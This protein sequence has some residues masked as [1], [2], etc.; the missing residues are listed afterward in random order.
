MS[1]L[2]YKIQVSPR[3]RHVRL[4]VTPAD[5]LCV[6]IPRGFD[7]NEVP[8]LVREKR[9]WVER[10]LRRCGGPPPVPDQA[11][12]PEVIDLPGVCELWRVT[13][14]PGALRHS[15][16]EDAAQ[17]CLTIITDR[18]EQA[19]VFAHLR[20]WLAG[21]AAA[22]LEPEVR[23][24]ADIHGFEVGRI[25]VRNQKSRWGSCSSRK[26]LSLNL[27]LLFLAPEQLHYVLIHELCHTR[28]MNHSLNF[29][30]HVAEIEPH[31]RVIN[32]SMRSAWR[33]VPAWV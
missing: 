21:R 25:S 32:R 27:K 24:L 11:C 30:E 1:A 17:A 26:N 20:R 33:L 12:L 16:R 4:K 23:R 15:L 2:D 22:V 18:P 9:A 19:R 7:P 8:E 29:W 6:V 28:V 14:Q 10:A 13:Y 5:G 31:Y 3:A